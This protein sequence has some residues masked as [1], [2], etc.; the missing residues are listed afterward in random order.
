VSFEV[1]AFCFR[2]ARVLERLR[3]FLL[4]AMTDV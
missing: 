4:D 3:K 2:T 1:A